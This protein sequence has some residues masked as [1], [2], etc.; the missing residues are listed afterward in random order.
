M[1]AEEVQR[2]VPGL[3]ALEHIQLYLISNTPLSHSRPRP[4]DIFPCVPF[5]ELADGCGI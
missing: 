3:S 2:D 1:N 5:P 4:S